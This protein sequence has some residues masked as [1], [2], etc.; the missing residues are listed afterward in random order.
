MVFTI[1]RA[2]EADWRAYRQ[3]RLRALLEAPEA[4]GSS[5]EFELRLTEGE[6]RARA[7]GRCLMLARDDEQRVVGTA[8][9]L[10]GE[11][12]D[13]DLVGMF[14]AA[15]VRG[16]GCAEL[17]L[18]AVVAVARED[19]AGRV[20]LH[21]TDGNLAAARCYRRYGFVETGRRWPMERDPRLTEIELAYH[22]PPER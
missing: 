12:G 19:G 4:Y 16:R 1:S 14:V 5:Y 15:D 8:A 7:A 2:D 13:L 9:G 20:V 10:P 18:D 17:L 3:I 6:W 21:I 11:D 22:V